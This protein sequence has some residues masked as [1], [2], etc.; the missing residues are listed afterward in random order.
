MIISVDK[1]TDFIGTINQ[2]TADNPFA[3]RIVSLYKSYKPELAFVDY[4]LVMDHSL[5]YTG[6]I[7]RSGS[8]FVLYLTEFSD[9]EEISSFMRVSGA[10]GIICDGKYKLDFFGKNPK[11]G[12]IMRKTEPSEEKSGD[13]SIVQPDIREAYYLI[14][15]AADKN[16]KPPSFE[17]FYVDMNHKLRHK[18]M[19]MYGVR[20][21]RRLV[22]VAMTVAESNKGAVLGAVAC[23][24][25]YRKSG[26]GSAVVSY[27]S[28]RIID[29]G[30][31]VYIHRAKN[32]NEKFY[33]KLGFTECGSW[34]EYYN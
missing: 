2:M 8:V 12:V 34:S 24:P 23:D 31:T 25:A 16:F 7:A 15:R 3:C 4:W 32:A 21:G 27:I 22:S 17:D 9:L 6:A 14:V 13:F 11:S 26:Y 18:T 29:D 19:R 1:S 33:D 28:N 20:R 10:S 30:K 5:R